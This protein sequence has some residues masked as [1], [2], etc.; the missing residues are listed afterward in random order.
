MNNLLFNSIFSK[1]TYLKVA[2]AFLFD[3]FI[4]I[5]S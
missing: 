1:K 5:T 4:S 3:T 2:I